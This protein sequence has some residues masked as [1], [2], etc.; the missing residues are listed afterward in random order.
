M[1]AIIPVVL[2]LLN[3]K[4]TQE[5][6]ETA[7]QTTSIFQA[8]RIPG[9][10]MLALCY[11]IIGLSFG[12][13]DPIFGPHMKQLGESPTYI[14][15]MFFLYSGVYAL[16]APGI[17][18][19]GDKTKCYRGMLILGFTGFGVS[20]LLLGPATF[21]PFL[22]ANKVWLV[23]IALPVCGLS[24]GFSF[25]PIM[26]DMFRTA[27]ANGMANNSSTNAVLSSI[28]GS[29]FY[30]GATIG[31]SIAG[32]FNEHFGFQWSTSI[33]GFIAFGHAMLLSAFTLYERVFQSS[34]SNYS[35]PEHEEERKPLLPNP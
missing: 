34:K 29:M 2:I 12:Y 6:D 16:S 5:S 27:R 20:Y 23:C 22:P 13:I 28:F 19:I 18:W 21:L 26:P 1:I 10:F 11:V 7:E 32:I 4:E 35:L 15:V 9:V 33:A 31:P 30:L 24:G 25:V 17:G 14:G 3:D 8:L